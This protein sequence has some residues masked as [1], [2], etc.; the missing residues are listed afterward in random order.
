MAILPAAHS[1]AVAAVDE[2]LKP[3]M[4]WA[5]GRKVA[6]LNQTGPA[7]CC[8]RLIHRP[9]KVQTRSVLPANSHVLDLSLQ[10]LVLGTSSLE[11]VAGRILR[12]PGFP[13]DTTMRT[14]NGDSLSYGAS[15]W[16]H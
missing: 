8:T 14:S 5:R 1:G 15:G 6:R 9:P 12:H 11:Y 7:L 13:D 16:G 4:M 10:Q 2:A 3:L